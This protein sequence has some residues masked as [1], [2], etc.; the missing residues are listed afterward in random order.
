MWV[1]E[2]SATNPS[3][4]RESPNEKG[5]ARDLTSDTSV[6]AHC[7]PCPELWVMSKVCVLRWEARMKRTRKERDAKKKEENRMAL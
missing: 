6:E 1:D 5:A 2:S 3:M 4:E 7:L